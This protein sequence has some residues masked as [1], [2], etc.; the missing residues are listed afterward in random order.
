MLKIYLKY[1]SFRRFSI[2]FTRIGQ[3]KTTTQVS[4]PLQ[5]YTN[6]NN[7]NSFTVGEVFLHIQNNS[8]DDQIYQALAVLAEKLEVESEKSWNDII[9]Y[10]TLKEFVIVR[11]NNSDL[12]I[13]KLITL[14]YINYILQ[15]I[16]DKVKLHALYMRI[17]KRLENEFKTLNLYKRLNLIS[18]LI[19]QI[20]I[21][22][23]K[24]IT[25]DILQ[26]FDR[27]DYLT[28]YKLLSRLNNSFSYQTTRL[29]F[30]NYFI[31]QFIIVSINEDSY[32]LAKTLALVCKLKSNIHLANLDKYICI[33]QEK[34]KNIT[35]LRTMFVYFESIKYLEV[36]EK[37]ITLIRLFYERLSLAI[38]NP[39][40]VD[41]LSFIKLFNYLAELDEAKF[42]PN[43]DEMVL[44]LQ[45]YRKFL[46]LSNKAYILSICIVMERANVYD[47][48]LVEDLLSKTAKEIV[49]Y[50]VLPQ[51]LKSFKSI[52]KARLGQDK[53]NV[54]AS[55]LEKEYINTNKLLQKIHYISL[56]NF[57][58]MDIDLN[59][60]SD[61]LNKIDQGYSF[62]FTLLKLSII[63]IQEIA[64]EKFLALLNEYFKHKINKEFIDKC[65]HESTL[66]KLYI[67][68]ACFKQSNWDEI[69]KYIIL[70]KLSNKFILKLRFY[71][72][73]DVVVNRNFITQLF[74]N[75]LLVMNRGKITNKKDIEHLIYIVFII[76]SKLGHPSTKEN[77][78]LLDI[79]EKQAANNLVHIPNGSSIL[80]IF[81][82]HG[83]VSK[84]LNESVRREILHHQEEHKKK[85]EYYADL[86]PVLPFVFKKDLYII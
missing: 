8:S 54:L 40:D 64:S 50:K 85:L 70:Q 65:E 56:L 41:G 17:Y 77:Q 58:G 61:E 14:L 10:K 27:L 29:T 37:N 80:N 53:L 60:L 75:L 35:Q 2:K 44:F 9:G 24:F 19:T 39:E 38:K 34:L 15:I 43:E 51:Y 23:E 4:S 63:Y 62:T 12:E 6:S 71:L 20:N 46:P 1:L 78:M 7:I 57:F 47:N 28:L 16:D 72:E 18:L 32:N 74:D 42:Y 25:D 21:D 5:K 30:L 82:K 36:N 22:I 67:E 69:L 31:E 86:V 3:S 11:I 83:L 13:E 79:I 48:N 33:L 59:H 49:N 45:H 73:G 52:V 81:T 55:A 26:N 84:I 76:T 66:I 68:L